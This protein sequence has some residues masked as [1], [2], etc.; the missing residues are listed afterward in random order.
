MSNVYTEGNAD[1][2][3]KAIEGL[4]QFT[5]NWCMNVAETEKG[6]LTFRCSECEFEDEST[7]SCRIKE[8]AFNHESNFDLGTFGAMGMH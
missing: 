7:G 5:E 4:D 1:N 2:I 3:D 8:F 6:D